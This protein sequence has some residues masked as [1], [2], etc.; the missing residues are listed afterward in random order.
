M[1]EVLD[2]FV[3]PG[4]TIISPFLGSG[5]ILRACYSRNIVGFG[6]DVDIQTKHRFLNK[7]KAD[8]IGKDEE[9]PLPLE[10]DNG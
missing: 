7:V 10:E 8:A 6:Y 4:S 1:Q 5:A 9:P 3:W 2:T